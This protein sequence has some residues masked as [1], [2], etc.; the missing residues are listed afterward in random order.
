MIFH[1]FLREGGLIKGSGGFGRVSCVHCVSPVSTTNISQLCNMYKAVSTTSVLCNMY[2]VE[3]G[4]A[5][6]PQ[7]S[8]VERRILKGG[9][10]RVWVCSV[11][12]RQQRIIQRRAVADKIQCAA[13]H[14]L[15]LKETILLPHWIFEGHEERGRFHICL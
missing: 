11:C 9:K 2:K 10:G 6:S 14:Q 4:T 7:V 15:H 3:G 13:N 8:I 5:G 12:L 1:P